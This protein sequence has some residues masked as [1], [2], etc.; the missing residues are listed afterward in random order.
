MR[1]DQSEPPNRTAPERLPVREAD[2]LHKSG[3]LSPC[4]ASSISALPVGPTSTTTPRVEETSSPAASMHLGAYESCHSLVVLCILLRSCQ[5][6]KND[7]TELLFSHVSAPV[8]AEVQSN[9]TLNRARNGGRGAGGAEAADA[10]NGGG[11]ECGVTAESLVWVHFKVPHSSCQSNPV[12]YSVLK[13]TQLIWSNHLLLIHCPWKTPEEFHKALT[14]H[15]ALISLLIKKY[16]TSDYE[17]WQF[18][19]LI[20]FCFTQHR[21][22]ERA[23][24]NSIHSL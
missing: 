13:K 20:P 11:G 17:I 18:W 5:A 4:T 6:F 24:A 9:V 12:Y 1:S 8:V 21:M 15:V 14:S 10:A 3:R 22:L 16:K 2:R 7:A 23:L 19:D